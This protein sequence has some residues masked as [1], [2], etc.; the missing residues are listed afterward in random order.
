MLANENKTVPTI[1][2]ELIAKI[3]TFI[4]KTCIQEIS[5]ENILPTSTVT[6]CRA[7]DVNLDTIDFNTNKQQEPPLALC[8]KIKPIPYWKETLRQGTQHC[9][10]HIEQE[11]TVEYCDMV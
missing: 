4:E 11:D 3:E 2:R 6:P 9:V 10:I 5:R 1:F 8:T 7:S